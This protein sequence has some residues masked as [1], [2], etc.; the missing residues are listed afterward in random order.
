MIFKWNNKGFTMVEL[1]VAMAFPTIRSI[2][3]NNQEKKYADKVESTAMKNIE[4][5]V[6]QEGKNYIVYDIKPCYAFNYSIDV[7][8]LK[9]IIMKDA[10]LVT[11]SD[12]NETEDRIN[13]I[14]D[15]AIKEGKINKAAP[16]SL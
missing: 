4:Y 2:Q 12:N 16:L 3:M 7:D 6:T 9:D 10:G 11:K 8:Y 1:L 15:K 14:I 5:K 13:S